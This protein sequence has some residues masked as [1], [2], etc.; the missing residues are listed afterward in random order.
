MNSKQHNK[1]HT[2]S[3]GFGWPDDKELLTKA[4]RAYHELRNH[5]EVSGL[6]SQLSRRIDND[7]Y[8]LFV[9]HEL[10]LEMNDVQKLKYYSVKMCDN[11]ASCRLD[12]NKMAMFIKKLEKR[13]KSGMTTPKSEVDARVF[14]ASL[15]L[16]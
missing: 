10:I 8:M 11:A 9:G 16:D 4:L 7:I 12:K 2:S 14:K 15:D 5:Y 1:P 13:Y 6:Y 3:T